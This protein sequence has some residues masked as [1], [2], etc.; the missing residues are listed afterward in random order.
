MTCQLEE[1]FRIVTVAVTTLVIIIEMVA[2]TIEVTATLTANEAMVVLVETV[3]TAIATIGDIVVIG[4]IG[5]KTGTATVEAIAT[6]IDIVT[7]ADVMT[8]E[9]P[10]H[11]G[12]VINGI[13]GG[14]TTT[15]IRDHA[16]MVCQV[17]MT[18]TKK[19]VVAKGRVSLQ[20][21]EANSQDDPQVPRKVCRANVITETLNGSI[22]IH[23]QQRRRRLVDLFKEITNDQAP[24]KVTFLLQRNEARKKLQLFKKR[25]AN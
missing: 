24:Q 4:V 18:C 7:T 2:E 19:F 15:E 9:V 1:G 22:R 3:D 14:G 11:D 6:R 8:D 13:A 10:H 16:M 21:L 23:Q 25:N 5:M 17:G 12:V 20:V